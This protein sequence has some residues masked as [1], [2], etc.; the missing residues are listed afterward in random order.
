MLRK[1][2]QRMTTKYSSEKKLNYPI[3]LKNYR[4]NFILTATIWSKYLSCHTLSLSNHMLNMVKAFKYKV[5]NSI[6]YTN[7]K[8]YRFWSKWFMYFLWQSMQPA[9]ESLTHLFYHCSRSKQ[10]WIVE[11]ELY[12]CLIS[13]QRIRL[14]LENVLFGILTKMLVLYFNSRLAL[15]RNEK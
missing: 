15:S 5:I 3:L 8:L 7:T 11:F 14:C 6:L 10:L 4:V 2:N 13:N 9:G 1:G 12:W